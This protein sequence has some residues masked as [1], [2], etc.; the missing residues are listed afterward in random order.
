M[1]QPRIVIAE[2]H[3]EV[4]EALRDIV[5]DL[6]E[7]VGIVRD[8]VTLVD[9]AAQLDPDIVIADISMPRMNGLEVTRA[10]RR[11]APNSKVI[12]LTVHRESI[13]ISLAFAAGARGYL[14][15]RS[16]AAEL[17]QAVMHVL[18]GD[19]YVGQGVEVKEAWGSPSKKSL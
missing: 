14:L 7:V 6:G 2:D 16:A 8:G 5:E 15:K 9:A 13:Y 12:I 18:A 19:Y 10:L 3:P 17:S 4:L 1:K 11:Y